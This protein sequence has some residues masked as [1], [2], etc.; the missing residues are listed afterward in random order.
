MLA[1][2]GGQPASDSASVIEINRTT[3]DQSVVTRVWQGTPVMGG[4]P[5]PVFV[6]NEE[7]VLARD[8]WIAVVVRAHPYRVDWRT[9]AGQW[10]RGAAIPGQSVPM[11][12]RE[13][14]AYWKHWEMDPPN[15]SV[16]IEWP[17]W[18]EPFTHP[19]PIA[20]PDGKVVVRRTPTADAPGVRYDVVNHRGEIEGQITLAGPHDQIAGFG[21]HSIYVLVIDAA[22]PRNMQLERRPWP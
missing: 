20:A 14:A 10:V 21:A 16:H 18:V 15:A 22:T 17:K 5:A 19:M 3:A 8:G 2:T 6:V 1:V 12:A 9:P 13:Q 7:P 11:D 4:V